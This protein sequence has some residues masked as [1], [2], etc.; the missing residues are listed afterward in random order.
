MNSIVEEA[1]ASSII[2][3]AVTTRKKAKELLKKKRKPRDKA[4]QMIYN[5]YITISE[6]K[7]L[8]NEPLSPIL[9]I[10]LQESI[11]K[12]TLENSGYEGRFR[13]VND[14]TIEVVDASG[15]LLHEPPPALEIP[16]LINNLGEFVNTE[17]EDD[18]IHPVIK[19]VIIHFWLAY[20]HPFMDGNGRTSRAL[21]YWYLL[22]KEF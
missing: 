2:E 3:G 22:K 7:E 1:I 6:I 13:V 18:F 9:L 5:N 14:C 16:E 11:P 15:H 17:S 10:K 8:I 4:E 19:G 21:F 20:I 12:D